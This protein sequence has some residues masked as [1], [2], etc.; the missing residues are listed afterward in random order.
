M[1][2]LTNHT[3]NTLSTVDP[4]QSINIA[5]NG[6]AGIATGNGANCYVS[7]QV[8]FASGYFA[9]EGDA[10]S[11]RI[12]LRART[13][14]GE[15]SNLTTDGTE[16]IPVEQGQTKHF[17]IR[18]LAVDE[19]DPTANALFEF[20]GLVS[21]L[22]AST[23]ATAPV[24]KSVRIRATAATLWD[25]D[26]TLDEDKIRISVTGVLGKSIRWIGEVDVLEIN[27]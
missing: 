21:R 6:G 24:T 3:T 11:S 9:K 17:R 23:E 25:A 1:G 2:L 27:N 5:P 7:N 26:V 16:E 14:A 18:V 20:D 19:T 15:T 10:Q 12:I 22:L 8:S 4:N 13:E